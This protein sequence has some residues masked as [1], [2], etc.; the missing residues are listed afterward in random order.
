[1]SLLTV[2]LSLLFFSG[3]AT[4]GIYAPD[5]SLSWEWV[6]ILS[7]PLC[8]P[9]SLSLSDSDPLALCVQTFNSLGQNACTVAAFMMSTCSGGCEPCY[10]LTFAGFVI[11]SRS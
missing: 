8:I 10:C 9:W 1:M 7:F 3:F 5:C 2:L 11:S 4:A 6:C